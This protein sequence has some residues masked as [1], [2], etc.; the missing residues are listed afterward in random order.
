MFNWLSFICQ[1]KN[2]KYFEKTQQEGKIKQCFF[3]DPDGMSLFPTCEK[4][5]SVRFSAIHDK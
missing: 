2:I 4:R 3:F 5:L 1:T